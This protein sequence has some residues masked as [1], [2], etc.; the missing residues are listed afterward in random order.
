MIEELKRE[1]SL[2]LGRVTSRPT[3]PCPV[4]NASTTLTKDADGVWS[5][6]LPLDRRESCY[7]LLKS[8][9]LLGCASLVFL[10][11]ANA[12]TPGPPHRFEANVLAYEAANKTNPP[13]QRG[14]SLAGDSN[15]IAGKQWRRICRAT[16]SSTAA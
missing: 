13:P 16:P 11:G 9:A 6:N 4:Q 1:E 8:L 12:Q 3:S 7:S 15:W 2:I 14:D 10:A 5:T